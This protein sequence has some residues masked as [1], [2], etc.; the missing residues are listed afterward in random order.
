VESDDVQLAL[1]EA[2]ARFDQ[3][4]QRA[5]LKRLDALLVEAKRNRDAGLVGEVL[6]VARELEA[7]SDPPRA[8]GYRRLV[9]GLEQNL[10]YL[11]RSGPAPSRAGVWAG[12]RRTA[13]MIGLCVVVPG[14]VIA[15]TGNT[16]VALGWTELGLIA[17]PAAFFV[18]GER[19]SASIWLCGVAAVYVLGSAG[20]CVLIVVF[21]ASA[22]AAITLGL[23]VACLAGALA[24]VGCV[25]SGGSPW[26]LAAFE[27][28]AVVGI[29]AALALIASDSERL[30][31][32]EGGAGTQQSVNDLS[33]LYTVWATA[34]VMILT[35]VAVAIRESRR[36]HEQRPPTHE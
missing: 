21:V 32:V 30:H 23:L 33:G 19:W 31:H 8:D 16:T 27:S 28:V 18:G 34:A 5:A 11:E 6:P 26:G 9:Y 22:G 15:A 3:G 36:R 4:D 35:G 13:A 20:V 7:R 1:S 12:R 2:R 25:A 14:L 24:L 10:A 17:S 29:G